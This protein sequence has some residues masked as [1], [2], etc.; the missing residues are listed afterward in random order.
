MKE[1]LKIERATLN[2]F[3]K[4]YNTDKENSFKLH[5]HRDKPD[6]EIINSRM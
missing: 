6:F 2:T 3:L 5:K 4:A 1:K